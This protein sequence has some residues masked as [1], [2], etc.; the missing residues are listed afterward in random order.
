MCTP[1]QRTQQDGT[2]HASGHSS[3]RKGTWGSSWLYESTYQRTISANH[4][5]KDLSCML[6]PQLVS[7]LFAFSILTSAPHLS[8]RILRARWSL[9]FVFP[10]TEADPQEPDFTVTVLSITELSHLTFPINQKEVLF[11][12]VLDFQLKNT[13]PENDLAK[14]TLFNSESYGR[15]LDLNLFFGSHIN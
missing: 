1:V 12:I 7:P 2:A 5:T 6:K 3:V 13:N 15:M 14:I 9:G 10:L 4:L 8:P 11:M